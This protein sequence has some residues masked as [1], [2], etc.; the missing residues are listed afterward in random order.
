MKEF[1]VKANVMADHGPEA[2][3]L[4]GKSPYPTNKVSKPPRCKYKPK[5]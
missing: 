2:I 4:L 1:V 5:R 3:H